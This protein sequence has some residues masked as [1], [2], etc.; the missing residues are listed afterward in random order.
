MGVLIFIAFVFVLLMLVGGLLSAQHA[1]I[2]PVV[3]W[4]H[5]DTQTFD[6]EID[7]EFDLED[8]LEVDLED[9]PEIDVLLEDVKK[10][11]RRIKKLKKRRHTAA[12]LP[13]PRGCRVEPDGMRSVQRLLAEQS[14]KDQ[15]NAGFVP[16]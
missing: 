11:K 8:D 16:P 3:D 2:K 9:D 1:V 4:L 7:V 12:T 14:A 5:P 6:F 13:R 15:R 10:I